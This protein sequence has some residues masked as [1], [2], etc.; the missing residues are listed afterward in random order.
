VVARA[1]HEAA[2]A[3]LRMPAADFEIV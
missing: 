3:I 2:Q 1:R